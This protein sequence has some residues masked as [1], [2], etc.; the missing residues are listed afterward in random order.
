[1]FAFS[2]YF[3]GLNAHR[4]F[5]IKSIFYNKKRHFWKLTTFVHLFAIVPSLVPYQHWIFVITHS[6]A[7][8]Q[9]WQPSAYFSLS[10]I[11]WSCLAYF[12]VQ[13]GI[14]GPPGPG[15]PVFDK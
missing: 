5:F 6:G 15:N 8:I 4:Y 1:M 3:I 9:N 14:F 10:G 2:S 13:F 11:F 7:V 12:D